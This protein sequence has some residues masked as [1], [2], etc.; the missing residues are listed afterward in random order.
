MDGWR[1][2]IFG[3]VIAICCTITIGI[4][5][6]YVSATS[7]TNCDR[8]AEMLEQIVADSPGCVIITSRRTSP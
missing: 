3:C 7:V 5:C 8:R 1:E 6:V 4:I 2:T